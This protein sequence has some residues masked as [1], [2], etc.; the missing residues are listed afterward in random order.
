MTKDQQ[1][2]RALKLLAPPAAQRE[3]CLHE[4]RLALAR[5]ENVT[6]LA[7]SSRASGS[8]TKGGLLR[9]H[10]ALR[11]L[12]SAF[13]SL[14]PAIRPWFSLADPAYTTRKAIDT[15]IAKA[16]A[17]LDQPQAPPRRDGSRNKA[18]VAAAYNLLKWR[19]HNATVTR[20]GTW[21]KLA[22][23]RYWLAI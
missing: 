15:E 10:A 14:D 13:D 22:K 23:L 2:Q 17:I 5:V 7:R 4:I 8:K 20:G 11:R 19:G 9:Y 21:G 16:K 12:L 1:I 6:A 18:A 3:E